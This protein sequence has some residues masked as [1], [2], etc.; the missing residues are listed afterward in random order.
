MRKLVAG[1]DLQPGYRD[2]SGCLAV[3]L[4]GRT[5][6]CALDLKPPVQLGAG[7]PS[8]DPESTPGGRH[9]G[10]GPGDAA[11]E[12]SGPFINGAGSGIT[13][14]I[15]IDR[16]DVGIGQHKS[17]AV[18]VSGGQGFHGTGEAAPSLW[19]VRARQLRGIIGAVRHLGPLAVLGD[20]A[21]HHPAKLLDQ[22]PQPGWKVRNI[23]YE[24]FRH[25]SLVPKK[26]GAPLKRRAGVQD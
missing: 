3:E 20:P 19:I 25:C 15:Q 4:D 8:D 24:G 13:T 11:D 17:D 5:V 26:A 1:A 2:V 9:F 23:A 22:R 12:I 16:S 10:I 14:T 21:P 6:L 7:T 18:G